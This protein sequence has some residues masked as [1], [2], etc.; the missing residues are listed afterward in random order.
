MAL[1]SHQL[2]RKA[3]IDLNAKLLTSGKDCVPAIYRVA[4]PL[5]SF[6]DGDLSMAKAGEVIDGFP[7][8]KGVVDGNPCA[9]SGRA[10]SADRHGGDSRRFAR[11][12]IDE[13]QALR[14]AVGEGFNMPLDKCRGP[15]VIGNKGC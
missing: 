14:A 1:K 10:V 9:P 4:V 6:D 7:N 3:R 15:E 11:H 12:G 2:H 13:Q 5:W 8:A